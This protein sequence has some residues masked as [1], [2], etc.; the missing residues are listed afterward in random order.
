MFQ[1]VK[2]MDCRPDSTPTFIQECN[3]Q[4]FFLKTQA[5]ALATHF[6]N[7][8]PWSHIWEIVPYPPFQAW[9]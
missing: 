1:I 7:A 9:K 2:K 5:L 3:L 6:G 4:H 8:F